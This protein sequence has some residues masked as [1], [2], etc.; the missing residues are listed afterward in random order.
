MSQPSDRSLTISMQ[1]WPFGSVQFHSK[2]V[3]SPSWRNAMFCP[4]TLEVRVLSYGVTSARMDPVSPTI[5]LQ[6]ERPF[7]ERYALLPSNPPSVPIVD[8][9]TYVQF[10]G[11]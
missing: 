10:P 3:N 2:T 4:V 6:R 5:M 8:I 1:V 9:S 11:M 7:N